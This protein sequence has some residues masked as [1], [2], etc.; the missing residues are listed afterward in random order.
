MAKSTART[1]FI[2]VH[3]KSMNQMRVKRVMADEA[4][5]EF[6]PVNPC[7]WVARAH[8]NWVTIKTIKELRTLG[9]MDTEH[10]AWL[11][12]MQFMEKELDRLRGV[13]HK[14]V[15]AAAHQ[16]NVAEQVDRETMTVRRMLDQ[17]KKAVGWPP[18][19]PKS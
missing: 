17:C 18:E 14:H 11:F 13:Y 2:A 9:Y 16:L 10:E 1:F 15:T 7:G 5:A 12:G 8:C 19:L 4:F 6:P 3:D